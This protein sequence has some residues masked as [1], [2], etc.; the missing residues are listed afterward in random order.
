LLDEIG[1]RP[2]LR[3][4][5]RMAALHLDRRRASPFRHELLR[6]EW[7]HRII[8]SSVEIRYQLGLDFQPPS[9]E[10]DR[11]GSRGVQRFS[12]E[13]YCEMRDGREKPEYLVTLSA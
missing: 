8:L 9:G 10:E 1:H 7:N 11:G 4:V 6:G 13:G 3:D 2:R 5:D 12:G